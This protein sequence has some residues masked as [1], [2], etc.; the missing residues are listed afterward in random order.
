MTN[1]PEDL[2][3]RMDRA[4]KAFDTI[5]EASYKGMAFRTLLAGIPTALDAAERL[6][7]I[8]REHMLAD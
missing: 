2:R 7:A 5:T 6:A 3:D 1:S 8:L 4:R